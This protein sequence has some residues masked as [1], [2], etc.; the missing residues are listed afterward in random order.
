V[1][2]ATKAAV[3]AGNLLEPKDPNAYKVYIAPLIFGLAPVINVLVSMFWHPKPGEPFHFGVKM[4]HPP[5]W[6]GIILGGLGAALVLYS[7]GWAGAAPAGPPPAKTDKSPTS[8][9]IK[10]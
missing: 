5:L 2:F 3:E 9:E 8:T 10:P 4:P 7:K 1:I 6:L